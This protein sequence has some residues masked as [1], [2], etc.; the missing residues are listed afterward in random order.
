M[1][2][3]T[4]KINWM[5]RN[6]PSGVEWLM[7]GLMRVS[8]WALRKELELRERTHLP[9]VQ[10]SRDRSPSWPRFCGEWLTVQEGKAQSKK[11]DSLVEIRASSSKT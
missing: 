11:S 8:K 7:N 5:A 9:E 4:K 10:N 1:D 3:S 2:T 6:W